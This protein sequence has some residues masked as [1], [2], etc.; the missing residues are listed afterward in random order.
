MEMLLNNQQINIIPYTMIE[1]AADSK[2]IKPKKNVESLSFLAAI[3][4]HI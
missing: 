2:D 3:S 1:I 4:A